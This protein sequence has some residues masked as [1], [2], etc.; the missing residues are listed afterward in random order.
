M[1]L[2]KLLGL[3]MILMFLLIGL[4]LSWLFYCVGDP[5]EFGHLSHTY[6]KLS[7]QNDTQRIENVNHAKHPV[8]MLANDNNHTY[9]TA[10]IVDDHTLISNYHVAKGNLHHIKFK[11]QMSSSHFEDSPTVTLT[12]KY[13]RHNKDMVVIHTRQSLRS[14]QKYQLTTQ[15]PKWFEPTTSIGYPYMPSISEHTQSLTQT[16]YRFLFCRGGRFYV[17]GTIYHGSSGSPMI[18]ANGRVY[19]IASFNYDAPKH[20]E[21][22]RISGGYYFSQS[23]LEWIHQHLQ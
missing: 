9:G 15:H 11:P 4:F 22:K 1:M 2:K 8:G 3:N 12:A 21:D 20:H 16:T 13:H 23:D 19:G 6:A 10:F 14:Y 18:H 7:N 17:A 5:G